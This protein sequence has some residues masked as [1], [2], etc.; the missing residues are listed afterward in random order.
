MF[1]LI[2]GRHVGAHVHEHQ[3]GG[4]IQI[5][6]NLG[7][8]FLRVSRLRKIAVIWILARVFAYLPSFFFQILDFICWT[9]FIFILIWRDT[10]NQQYSEGC[11]ENAELQNADLENADIWFCICFISSICFY[12][13]P[14]SVTWLPLHDIRS[15]YSIIICSAI[16]DTVCRPPNYNVRAFRDECNEILAKITRNNKY[17]YLGAD[18]NL[19]LFHYSDHAPTQEF[20]DSQYFPICSFL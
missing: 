18:Y 5:T 19:D 20:V 3:H 17:C 9:V 11:L 7:K 2:S 4:S 15:S 12:R 16:V 6:I 14:I 13:T 8:T 1:L 10:E